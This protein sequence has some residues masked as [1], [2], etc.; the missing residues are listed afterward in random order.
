M[1]LLPKSLR[2]G[3]G[4]T[5]TITPA[6]AACCPSSLRAGWPRYSTQYWS[7]AGR[8]HERLRRRRRALDR[9]RG[10][11]CRS[12]PA[13]VTCV[14][15]PSSNFAFA[16]KSPEPD[17]HR[18]VRVAVLERA[19]AV[20][21][22]VGEIR[23]TEPE[24]VAELVRDQVRRHRAVQE[25]RRRLRHARPRAVLRPGGRR[26][27]GRISPGRS[28]LPSR[29]RCASARTCGKAA[30]RPAAE[31]LQPRRDG[32]G[33]R[34]LP[35]RHRAV[36]RVDLVE[37]DVAHVVTRE[38]LRAPGHERDEDPLR[39]EHVTAVGGLRGRNHRQAQN[40]EGDREQPPPHGPVSSLRV[41]GSS[42]ICSGLTISAKWHA[43]GWPWPRSISAGSSSA[44]IGCAFQQRV[45][46][47]QPDGGF[48]GFGTS[49][50][51][52]I[53]LRFPRWPGSSIG[54]AE[55]SAC[56]YG[57]EGRS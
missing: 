38:R 25:D 46:N 42:A 5:R 56:V 4:L 18:V 21:P 34:D 15:Q 48:A 17:S 16:L 32:S 8:D 57:C 53:R 31:R 12:S 13:R 45:R 23:V 6:P 33:Q 9:R 22:A 28:R 35:V 36:E 11:T 51:S 27:R 40:E 47:R 37:D 52:T 19:A 1:P 3:L 44:Q 54:I 10:R 43:L 24:R 14:I 41:S 30:A 7:C 55:S 20:T 39:A 2:S 26:R 29:R 50:S 49:P